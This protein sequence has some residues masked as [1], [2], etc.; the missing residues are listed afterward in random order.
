MIRK[1]VK[2]I[3]LQILLSILKI[4]IST[5]LEFHL[6]ISTSNKDI[7]KRKI[8]SWIKGKNVTEN[9]INLVFYTNVVKLVKFMLHHNTLTTFIYS[10]P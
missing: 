5:Y 2:K 8:S 1:I 10:Y 4:G 6:P 7:G 3:K 9:K